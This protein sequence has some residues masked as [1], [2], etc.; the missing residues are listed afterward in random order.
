MLR[1]RVVRPCEES[2]EAMP[3]DAR[4]RHCDK[5]EK[6]VHDLAS[7][8]EVE[9][10]AMLREAKRR[11]ERVCVRFARTPDG[12]VRLRGVGLAATLALAACT[13][14]VEQPPAKNDPA[15]QPAP[16]EDH[17]M[18]DAIPDEQDRCPDEPDPNVDDGCPEPAKK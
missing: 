8:T 11:G 18:G 6:T 13:A 17:D 14:P 7:R 1:L 9:V 5:C 2:F 4:A 10:R 12:A 16:E 3:G 15:A